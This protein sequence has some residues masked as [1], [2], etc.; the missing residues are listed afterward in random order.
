MDCWRATIGRD[1]IKV[2]VERD[3]IVSSVAVAFNKQKK[4]AKH[5]RFGLPYEQWMGGLRSGRPPSR[6]SRVRRRV[7]R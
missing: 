5:M 7:L 3:G 4:V 2:G 6:Y 1:N